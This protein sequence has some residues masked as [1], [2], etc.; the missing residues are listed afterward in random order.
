[1]YRFL[2]ANVEANAAKD[3]P[4]EGYVF[5]ALFAFLVVLWFFQELFGEQLLAQLRAKDTLCKKVT[6]RLFGKVW[7]WGNQL[8]FIAFLFYAIYAQSITLA[9]IF[10]LISLAH[11]IYMVSV[12]S[13]R[14]EITDS[15][16]SYKTVFRTC[17]MDTSMIYKACWVSK[18]RSLGYTLVLNFRNGKNIEFPQIYFVG[19][20]DL[21]ERYGD[22]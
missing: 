14:I 17:E 13:T 22:E 6:L 18:G 21:W 9:T 8:M 12:L 10:F 16:L 4:Y 3:V 11:G 15:M 2:I 1:M 7:L 19:L 5:G 20:N